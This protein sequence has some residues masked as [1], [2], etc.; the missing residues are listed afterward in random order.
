MNINFIKLLIVFLAVVFST[1]FFGFATGEIIPYSSPAFSGWGALLAAIGA[2]GSFFLLIYQHFTVKDSTRFIHIIKSNTFIILVGFA[3]LVFL[4]IALNKSNTLIPVPPSD[5]S[6]NTIEFGDLATW[7]AAFGTVLTLGFAI[8]QNRQ[9]R[10]EQNKEKLER[11]AE[12]NKHKHNLKVERDKREEHERK[13]QNMWQEQNEHLSFKKFQTHKTMFTEMLHELENKFKDEFYFYDIDGLYEE[14]FPKNGFLS[15]Q[16]IVNLESAG[17]NRA[18]SL[19]DALDGYLFLNESLDDCHKYTAN[20]YEHSHKFLGQLLTLSSNLHIDFKPNSEYGGVYADIK[21]GEPWFLLNVFSPLRTAIIIEHVLKRLCSFTGNQGAVVSLSH[22]Q[23]SFL[24][25][26][27]QN[28]AFK[29]TN[30]RGYKFSTYDMGTVIYLLNDI[31]NAL[32]NYRNINAIG[33]NERYLEL[34]EL[35]TNEVKMTIYLTRSRHEIKMSLE[36]I[37]FFLKDL[38][39]NFV[40]E[41]KGS[42][43]LTKLEKRATEIAKG[44]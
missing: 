42:K 18:G 7:V 12:E 28:F 38:R 35:F 8:R 41:G 14:L 27:L 43:Q 11:K 15:C 39:Q 10:E 21:V 9:L 4:S 19:K 44:L 29:H 32:P 3:G 40:I 16:T 23:T 36:N 30:L 1:I 6:A 33:V 13:Q 22:K 24:F 17:E 25:E 2:I 26:T 31:K 34:S 20:S 5:V 37:A